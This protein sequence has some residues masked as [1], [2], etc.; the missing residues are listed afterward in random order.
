MGNSIRLAP[1][2][3][4][5]LTV[6]ISWSEII[7]WLEMGM[8]RFRTSNS[9]RW[10]DV[11][12][13]HRPRADFYTKPTPTGAS[14][15]NNRCY[16]YLIHSPWGGKA[17]SIPGE[18]PILLSPLGRPI[19]V[20]ESNLRKGGRGRGSVRAAHTQITPYKKRAESPLP[21]C[22]KKAEFPL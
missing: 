1:H 12:N 8:R 21:P 15:T 5:E 13:R 18:Y 4:F 9:R 10:L 3:N 7:R 17:P 22:K 20:N 19:E 2:A 16:M 6:T 14:K 11:Q